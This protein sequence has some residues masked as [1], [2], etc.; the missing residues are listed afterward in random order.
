MKRVERKKRKTVGLGGNH[1]ICDHQEARD[2]T[3]DVHLVFLCTGSNL[4]TI[5]P[6]GGVN[7]YTF[8][9]YVATFAYLHAVG[10]TKKF[11][12]ISP[13]LVIKHNF[14]DYCEQGLKKRKPENWFAF[15]DSLSKHKNIII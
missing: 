12:P 10:K 2:R 9:E 11:N 14:C 1:G 13:P 6:C 7:A 3:L 4:I 8:G 15:N 5:Y